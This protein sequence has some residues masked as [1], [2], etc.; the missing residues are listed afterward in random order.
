MEAI[1]IGAVLFDALTIGIV[2]GV[3]SSIAR[4]TDAG[5]YLYIGPEIGV[6]SPKAFTGQV[7]AVLM[8]ALTMARKR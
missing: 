8:I 5:V 6:A 1:R 2:N 4:L 7:I 3:G